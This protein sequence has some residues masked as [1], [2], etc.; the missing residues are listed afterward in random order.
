MVLTMV[1]F[2]VVTATNSNSV[3][4]A[5]VPDGGSGAQP[6]SFQAHPLQPNT[7]CFYISLAVSAFPFFF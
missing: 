7:G 5:S 6:P 2:D 3:K 1:V 4:E